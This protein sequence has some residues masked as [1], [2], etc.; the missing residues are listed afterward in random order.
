MLDPREEMMKEFISSH[1]EL[2]EYSSSERDMY[3]GWLGNFV[4]GWD[5]AIAF[6]IKKRE[7]E[8][9]RSLEMTKK[10]AEGMKKK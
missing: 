10:I 8:L 1:G 9:A 4:L 3:M 2:L 5:A 7:E 6:M